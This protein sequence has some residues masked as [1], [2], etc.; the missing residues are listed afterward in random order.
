MY[1][2]NS[3][4]KIYFKLNERKIY[5]MQFTGNQNVYGI[6]WLSSFIIR[7]YYPLSV[8]ICFYF[9]CPIKTDRSFFNFGLKFNGGAYKRDQNWFIE[10]D[11]KI[12]FTDLKNSYDF[13]F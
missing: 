9:P 6:I 13:W 12:A 1:V 4:D 8:I 11:F 10:T 3:F 5:K 2:F 7:R